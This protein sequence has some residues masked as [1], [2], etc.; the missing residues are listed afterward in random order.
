MS[1]NPTSVVIT[2]A[3]AGIGEA[4]ARRFDREDYHLILLAR[5]QEKLEALKRQLSCKVDILPLDV[6]EK[7]AVLDTFSRIED[8]GPIDILVNNAGLAL[9]LDPAQKASLDDW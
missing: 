4:I 6:K 8:Q 1:K 5:R 9:G 3:S 7:T 2:G